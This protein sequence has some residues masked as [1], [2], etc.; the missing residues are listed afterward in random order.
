MAGLWKTVN[1]ATALVDTG[2]RMDDMIFEEF[3]G[4]GNWELHLSRELQERRVFPAIDIKRSGTRHDELLYD[5]V[6]L[7]Q[8]WKLHRALAALD[9]V[10]AT[11]LLIDRLRNTKSNE[12]FLKIVEKTLRN[13]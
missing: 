8:I 5:D 11:E 12:E 6:T 7:K 9:T 1:W 4:T 10:Q 2:S 3:K 13:D